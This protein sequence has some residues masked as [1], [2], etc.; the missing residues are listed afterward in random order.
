MALSSAVPPP[1]SHTHS[2][3]VRG[4]VSLGSVG[5]PPSW[6]GVFSSSVLTSTMGSLDSSFLLL[7]GETVSDQPI[8]SSCV[9][10]W[11]LSHMTHQPTTGRQ[12]SLVKEHVLTE[13][14]QLIVNVLKTVER[15]FQVSNTLIALVHLRAP[16]APQEACLC[17]C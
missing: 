5:P 2:G 7:G 14:T 17:W 6:F 9:C 13:N 8:I 3:S 16:V 15:S 12:D 11:F 1:Q 10:V 4:V